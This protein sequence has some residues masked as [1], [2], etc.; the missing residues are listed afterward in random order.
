MADIGRQI[1]LPEELTKEYTILGKLGAGANGVVLHGKQQ[2]LQRQVAIKLLHLETMDPQALQRFEDEA[3]VS[4]GLSHKNIVGVLDCNFSC[5]QPFVVFEYVDGQT[6]LDYV[7]TNRLSLSMVDKIDLMIAA[8]DG[9][10]YSHAQ[11]VVHRDI[12]PEN[13]MVDKNKVVKITDFGLA[14]QHG[15]KVRTKTGIIVGTP[16]YISPEQVTGHKATAASDV[17]SMGVSLFEILA[18]KRPYDGDNIVD[19]IRMHVREPVPHLRS[20][21]LEAPAALDDLVTRCLAKKPEERPSSKEA[22][23][24]LRRIKRTPFKRE[25]TKKHPSLRSKASTSPMMSSNASTMP[26]GSSRVSAAT[27]S[28][29]DGANKLRYLVAVIPVL[30]LILVT[31]LFV[32]GGDNKLVRNFSV[33]ATGEDACI[34][35]WQANFKDHKPS[36][37]VTGADDKGEVSVGLTITSVEKFPAEHG[38]EMYQYVARLSGLQ[39]QKQYRV[40]LQKPDGS[41]TMAHKARTVLPY[42]EFRVKADSEMVSDGSVILQLRSSQ[43]FSIQSPGLFSGKYGPTIYKSKYT[44]KSQLSL[45]IGKEFQVVVT[46]VDGATKRYKNLAGLLELALMPIYRLFLDERNRLRATRPKWLSDPLRNYGDR[47]RQGLGDSELA[48]ELN[49]IELNTERLLAK[50]TTWFKPLSRNLGGIKEILKT[51]EVSFEARR[52]IDR[53]MVPLEIIDGMAVKY[54]VDSSKWWDGLTQPGKRAIPIQFDKPRISNPSKLIRFNNPE[55]HEV[56]CFILDPLDKMNQMLPT[57]MRDATKKKTVKCNLDGLASLK[58]KRAELCVRVRSCYTSMVINLNI[59]DDAYALS[60]RDR[61]EKYLRSYERAIN[62][63]KNTAI[64]LEI[65]TGGFPKTMETFKKVTRDFQLDTSPVDRR[66][67]VDIPV[68]C[69]KEGENKV[70]IKIYS[71]LDFLEGLAFQELELRLGS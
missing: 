3:R 30:L 55:G 71:G 65:I 34:V 26:L 38:L 59:N 6:L 28:P 27:S 9:L 44:L 63:P 29:P 52:V 16:Q 18:G 54:F 11:G 42:R 1:L 19:I 4:A 61:Y 36:F 45:L 14:K 40:S 21:V 58:A 5:R 7:E 60:V 8:F 49:Q 48:R 33:V 64:N 50:H 67:Y 53:A 10:A 41:T 2:A 20:Y 68:S 47:L 31:C 43:R 66:M 62:D 23:R 22:A 13:I 12:K 17:Y 37:V 24:I 39:S 35:K 32:F 46:S 70:E 15:S 51:G 57:A 69:L 56:P 25:R